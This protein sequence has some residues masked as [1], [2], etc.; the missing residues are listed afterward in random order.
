MNTNCAKFAISSL[1]KK[2]VELRR[3]LEVGSFDVNGSIRPFV[4]IFSPGE[5][6]G[7][8]IAAGR[9]VDIVCD[10]K[11][12]TDR[13]GAASFDIVISTELVEHVRD[14]RTA[15]HQIKAVCKPGGI[16]LITTRSAGFPY[17][18][19][20]FDFWRYEPEDMEHIFDDC[21]VEKL[22]RDPDRG[23]FIKARKPENFIE[24]DLSDHKLYSIVVNRR[25]RDL[26][27]RE[28]K[29]L[30]SRWMRLKLKIRNFLYWV[31]EVIY[32]KL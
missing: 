32:F 22:E 1:S 23:V 29:S 10:V 7:V 17:H 6:I 28:L 16:I 9:G 2:E 3:V 24:N 20:P 27:D 4:E 14:W 26:S 8:D 18:G 30:P 15:M 31:A 11:D 5:Y 12:L 25:V 19:H 21:I 13:F